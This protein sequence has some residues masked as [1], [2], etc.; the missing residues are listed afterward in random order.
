MVEQCYLEL[1]IN[2]WYVELVT[3]VV[4]MVACDALPE[5]YF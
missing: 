1:V 5:I 3:R 4:V 2:T